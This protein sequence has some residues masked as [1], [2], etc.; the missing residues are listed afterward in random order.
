M[1][2]SR[3]GSAASGAAAAVG[4]GVGAVGEGVFKYAV[5]EDLD[6]AKASALVD[7]LENAFAAVDQT[8]DAEL[9]ALKAGWPA[10]KR[11]VADAYAAGE[12]E[13]MHFATAGSAT[14]KKALA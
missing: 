14:A 6:V 9:S 5:G 13:R 7:K 3:A 1:V 11:A 2:R 10:R 12:A 4:R 8:L